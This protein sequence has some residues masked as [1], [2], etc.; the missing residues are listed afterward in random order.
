MR[1]HSPMATP[2]D[3]SWGFPSESLMLKWRCNAS[4]R[5]WGED[6]EDFKPGFGRTRSGDCCRRSPHT[7][8]IARIGNAGQR[9]RA[10]TRHSESRA[11][12]QLSYSKLQTLPPRRLQDQ[13][14]WSLRAFQRVTSGQRGFT[15]PGPA[16][17]DGIAAWAGGRGRRAG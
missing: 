15:R 9:R 11:R 1:Y 17:D 8:L 10:H 5:R 16:G 7:R 3:V 14:L 4:K 12:G 2:V 6:D 13:P